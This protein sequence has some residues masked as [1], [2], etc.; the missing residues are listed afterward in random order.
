SELRGALESFGPDLVPLFPELGRAERGGTVSGIER[1]RLPIAVA[2]FLAQLSAAA[3]VLLL[4]PD[5]HW[6]DDASLQLLE[7]LAREVA[8]SR[9]V[10]VATYRGDELHRLH[11]LQR[12]VA[13]IR[14]DRLAREIPLSP[15]GRDQSA[16]LI[17]AAA[18]DRHVSR[19]VSD[20]IFARAQGNPFFT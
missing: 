19:E 16:A 15:L 18:E 17:S 4:L 7:R 5:I 8:R 9:L 12:A 2:T 13:A 20:A 6:A 1:N 14:R 3:P 10:I 11:P